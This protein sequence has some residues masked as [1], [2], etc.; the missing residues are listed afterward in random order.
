MTEQLPLITANLTVWLALRRVTEGGVA[1]LGGSYYQHGRPVP[2]YLNAPLKDLIDAGRLTLAE[3]D[4]NSAGMRK[5]TLTDVG[6]ELYA[7]LCGKR[8]VSESPKRD[9]HVLD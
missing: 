1:L 8:G 2:H 4:L 6:R 5:V 7:T 9:R 3:A